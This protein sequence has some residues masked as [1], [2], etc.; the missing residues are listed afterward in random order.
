VEKIS[1]APAGKLLLWATAGTMTKPLADGLAAISPSH[2]AFSTPLG[3]AGS[4]PID[5]HLRA[6]LPH[7]RGVLIHRV[8]GGTPA[9]HLALAEAAIGSDFRHLLLCDRDPLDRLAAAWRESGDRSL[10]AM[11]RMVRHAATA[12]DQLYRVLEALRLTNQPRRMVSVEALSS[13]SAQGSSP[14]TAWADLIEFLGIEPISSERL[15]ALHAGFAQAA[16]Q[17]THSEAPGMLDV[18]ALQ[19]ELLWLPGPWVTRASLHA[20]IEIAA[21]Q[22]GSV[23]RFQLHSPPMLIEPDSVWPI[24][25]SLEAPG[26]DNGSSTVA[27]T[28]DR[29][30]AQAS[31]EEPK[32]SYLRSDR[33]PPGGAVITFRG[34][35]RRIKAGDRWRFTHRPTE[36]AGQALATLHF[37]HHPQP[38]IPG[39]FVA[40]W[41]IGYQPIPKAAGTS[42]KEALFALAIGEKPS[43]GNMDGARRVDEYFAT[44]SIDVSGAAFK[45]IVIRDPLARFLS[46]FA[47][48]VGQHHELSEAY[49]RGLPSSLQLPLQDFVFDPSLSQFIDCFELYMRVPT[50][51]HHF[52]PVADQVLSLEAFDKVYPLESMDTLCADIG[53]WTG[54]PF[55]LPREQRSS[56][57]QHT[58]ALSDAQRR[59]IVR[60][61]E[62]DYEMLK[63]HYTPGGRVHKGSA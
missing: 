6:A 49:L 18:A 57:G 5:E 54:R 7:K 39:I 63:A 26:Q 23:R 38:P 43:P 25:G 22:G 3:E 17:L 50:I 31:S 36:S 37:D 13:G 11:K 16:S 48:R 34:L 41:S 47:N 32:A 14:L 53:Q 58:E 61:C 40:P 12:Q 52:Q 51:H 44:R 2:F 28:V 24:D 42:I 4:A 21:P 33:T 20:R 45:F 27:L 46:A 59:A 10:R 30:P 62:R 8:D 35:G 15:Q 56:S 9:M 29:E 60:I 19:R 55:T 1:P